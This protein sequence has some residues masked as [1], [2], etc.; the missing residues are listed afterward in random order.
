M[1]DDDLKKIGK[2]ILDSE[3]RIITEMGSFVND[4]ILPQIEEKADK[5]DLENLATK[6]DINRVERKLDRV[7]GN[8]MVQNKRLSDIE[9]IPT[10]ALQLKIKKS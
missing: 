4:T 9:S 10:I 2:L 8:D 1:N 6:D 7:T 3:E 5:S